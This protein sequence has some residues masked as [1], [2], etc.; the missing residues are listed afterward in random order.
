MTDSVIAKLGGARLPFLDIAKGI[1]IIMV[2]MGHVM[3]YCPL[4]YWIYGFH[5]PLFFVISGMLCNYSK[6]SFSVF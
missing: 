2:V 5:V 4:Y 3:P 6:Y 1:G